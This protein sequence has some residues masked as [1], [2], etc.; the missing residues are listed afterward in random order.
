MDNRR[1]ADM[2]MFDS[3]LTGA[4]VSGISD[5]LVPLSLISTSEG[6]MGVYDLSGLSDVSLV[7]KGAAEVLDLI[8]RIMD[9][10]DS[11]KDILIFPEDIILSEK[12]IFTDDVTGK[13]RIC[14]IH[15][16]CENGE[17]ESVAYL[18]DRLKKIT[19]L[20]GAEYLEILKREY[21]EHNYS[22][23]GLLALIEDMKREAGP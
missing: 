3:D 22:R 13:V 4:M 10:L 8:G 7:K 1:I 6:V 9:A 23:R 12:V 21:L 11:L 20:R 15:G 14:V 16:N 17:K 18:I 19:D 2:S 5:A